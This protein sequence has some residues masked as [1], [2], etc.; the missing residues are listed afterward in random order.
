MKLNLYV[1]KSLAQKARCE[2]PELIRST[3]LRKYIATV[4]QVRIH[5]KVWRG[6]YK[7]SYDMFFSYYE[8]VFI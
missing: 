5:L 1:F 3:R 4:S 8:E 2:Q 6:G 7:F